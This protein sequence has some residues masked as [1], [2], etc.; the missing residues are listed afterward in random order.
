MKGEKIFAYIMIIASIAF[1]V[2]SLR[3]VPFSELTVSSSGGY[4][5]FISIFCLILAIVIAFAKRPAGGEGESDKS[6]FDPVIMA[7]IVML[8][9]YV[10]GI[11]Y[12]HYVPATL[13]FLFAALFY[14]KRDNWKRAILISY[15]STFMILLVFKYLFSVIMP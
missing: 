6:V 3:I 2:G 5:I 11:I 12:I 10:I 13:L 9:L 15:I 14:L 1:L 4:A 8:V 7:F